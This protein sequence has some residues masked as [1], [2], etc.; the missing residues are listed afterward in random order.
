ML[1]KSVLLL[2]LC[3]PGLLLAEQLA[4]Q[5]TQAAPDTELLEFLALFEQRDAE[6]VDEIID[7]QQTT[8]SQQ[9][10]KGDSHEK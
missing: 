1:V 7:E 9:Q 4:Q 10:T 8:L 6:V 2:S 5:N 3:W